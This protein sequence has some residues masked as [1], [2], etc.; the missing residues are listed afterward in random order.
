[1]HKITHLLPVKNGESL[2]ARALEQVFS[3]ASESDEIVIV[4]DGST[5]NTL[6]IIQSKIANNH[7]INLVN[8]R[9]LGLANALNFGLK[10]SS[11][12]WIA[13]YDVDD[14]YRSDRIELQKSLIDEDTG[15]IFSDYSLWSES[16]RYLGFLPSPI[17][18][19]ATVLSLLSNLQTAHPSALLNKDAVLAV[20]GYRQTDFPAE[21]LG[22]WLRLSRN[23]LLKSVPETLLLYQKTKS[24]VTGTK[25]KLAFSIK[26]Q[27]LSDIGLPWDVLETKTDEIHNTIIDYAKYPN[28]SL[29]SLLL[30][31]NI[32]KA[33]NYNSDFS[34]PNE[35]LKDLPP[36]FFLK[37]PGTILNAAY[38]RQL[39]RFF[40]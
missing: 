27:L 2:I 25:R 23:S 4:N 12:T 36:K 17:E 24:G 14:R 21:D 26:Q 20:G 5:D 22:L 28:E 3:M 31:L 29:R 6:K 15:A 35:F 9:G 32:R 8:S 38:Y 13:R 1:M 37:A 19:A 33:G 16:N 40:G 18:N 30:L 11:N 39:R 7:P 34:S 10:V